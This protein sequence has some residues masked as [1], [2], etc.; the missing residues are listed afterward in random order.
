LAALAVAAITAQDRGGYFLRSRCDLVPEANS[1]A[2]FQIIDA[3]GGVETVELDSGDASRL[4]AEAVKA[5]NAAGIG[6][7]DQDLVLRPQPK[8]VQLVVA[9]RTLAL[10]GMAEEEAAAETA[11]T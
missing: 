1:G 3:D 6:W 11:Q 7:N 9:S 5:A 2:S 8:L 4:M 10:Q